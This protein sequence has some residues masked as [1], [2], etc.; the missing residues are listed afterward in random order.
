ADQDG[1]AANPGCANDTVLFLGAGQE[2]ARTAHL[3]ALGDAPAKAAAGLLAIVGQQ[4]GECTVGASSCGIFQDAPQWGEHPRTDIKA[5]SHPRVQMRRGPDTLGQEGLE[6]RDVD[7]GALER[8][9]ISELRYHKGE[10][11]R[12]H[13]GM[14][15]LCYDVLR[16]EGDC[17]CDELSGNCFSKRDSLRSRQLAPGDPALRFV[18]TYGD[19]SCLLLKGHGERRRDLT[20]LPGA[21]KNKRGANV[22]VPGKRHLALGREDAHLACLPSLSPADACT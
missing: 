22:W 4:S 18:D 12:S 10:T 11:D 20:K 6:P 13:L 8:C 3:N 21:G 2:R 17:G 5:V 16:G 7:A 15:G 19:Y 1:G 14:M 9:A